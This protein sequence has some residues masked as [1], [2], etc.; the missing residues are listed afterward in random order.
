MP[1][2]AISS[3]FALF[4]LYP[5]IPAIPNHFLHIFSHFW[6]ISAISNQ[7]IYKHLQQFIAIPTMSTN[8]Q[9]FSIIFS[10]FQ[11]VQPLRV[12]ATICSF[13]CAI[14]S[15]LQTVFVILAIS[16]KYF[17]PFPFIPEIVSHFQPFPAILA[18]SSLQAISMHLGHWV[19]PTISP[20]HSPSSHSSHVWPFQVITS[21]LQ[22]FK[23]SFKA[24]FSLF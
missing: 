15:H 5:S 14:F 1:Y 4:M 20:I 10:Y 24:N 12:I 6:L 11:P 18:M 3:H 17:E 7:S 22:S 21:H 23:Q 9:Q 8:L 16:N 19:I 2:P 13:V